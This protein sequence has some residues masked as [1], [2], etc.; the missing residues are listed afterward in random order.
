MRRPGRYDPLQ[1]VPHPTWL[2]FRDERTTEIYYYREL[3]P[4]TDLRDVLEAERIKFVKGGWFV[5][6]VTQYPFAFAK[7]NGKRVCIVIQALPPN[8]PTVGHG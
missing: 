5:D 1:K 7:R 2:V 4:N 3:E 6:P 8:A